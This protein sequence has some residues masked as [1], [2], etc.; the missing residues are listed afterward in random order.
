MLQR[1]AAGSL[2]AANDNPIWVA[3]NGVGVLGCEPVVADLASG[4]TFLA[5][6]GSDGIAHGHI[7]PPE[8]QFTSDGGDHADAPE[9]A[10]VNASLAD[11][12]PVV[13]TPEGGRRLSVAEARPGSFAVMWLALA[14]SNV[15]LRGSLFM[16]PLDS[17]Q[18]DDTGS[19]AATPIADIRPPAGFTGQFALQAADDGS[20]DVVVTYSAAGAETNSAV[21]LARRIEG[22]STDGKMGQASPEFVVTS[23][24]Q[25]GEASHHAGSVGWGH[26][27]VYRSTAS[28]DDKGIET[29]PPQASEHVP[30]AALTA[31]PGPS[32]ITPMVLATQNGFTIAWEAAGE[33]EGAFAIK[34]TVFEAD[35]T[36]RTLP[37]GGTVIT[38]TD[39][40]RGNSRTG[41]HWYRRWSCCWICGR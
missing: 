3:Q 39:F 14:E 28:G 21:T 31:A 22:S 18:G 32:A 5:W 36:A 27:A 33:S 16:K 24:V 11:L 37:D 4:D 12:G 35:G 41:D 38:V 1:Y 15:V 34:M 23:S 7:Y 8:R 10:A 17:Q 19:W 13:A 9:Y 26:D 40:S 6:V 2:N 29:A 30:M 25:G 20:A